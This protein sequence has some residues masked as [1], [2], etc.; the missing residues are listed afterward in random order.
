M[1]NF[2]KKKEIVNEIVDIEAIEVKMPPSQINYY[3]NSQNN[4]YLADLPP[5]EVNLSGSKQ[6]KTEIES[7]EAIQPIALNQEE[8]KEE[9]DTDTLNS[10]HLLVGSVVTPKEVTS[11]NINNQEPTPQSVIQP[12]TTTNQNNINNPS[13]S[14]M[15]SIRLPMQL[16]DIVKDNPSEKVRQAIKYT[17]NIK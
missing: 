17:Y 7:Q 10:N 11:D 15:V 9:R 8:I 1:F 3:G 2:F 14:R 6:T 12:Y 13:K 5:T 4:T 16:Y